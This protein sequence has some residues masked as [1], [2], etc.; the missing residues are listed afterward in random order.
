MAMGIA[1]CLVFSSAGKNFTPESYGRL[2]YPFWLSGQMDFESIL[3]MKEDGGLSGSLLLTPT[4][5]VKAWTHDLAAEFVSGKDFKV[6][7]RIVYFLRGAAVSSLTP[8]ELYPSKEEDAVARVF[9]IRSGGFVLAPRNTLGSRQTF[10]SYKFNPAEWDGPRPE[11]QLETLPRT[12]Q[13]LEEK[14]PLNILFFGDSITEGFH[15]SKSMKCAPMLPRWDELVIDILRSHYGCPVDSLNAS[16]GGT[17]SEWGMKTMVEAVEHPETVKNLGGGRVNGLKKKLSEYQPDLVFVAFGMN[18]SFS[19]VDYKAHIEG[20][21][22]AA[23]RRNP[24]VEFVL[25]ES[26]LPNPRWKGQG[27]VKAYWDVLRQIAKAEKGVITVAV[28]PMHE[29]MLERKAYGDLSANHANHPNDFLIRIH[30]QVILSSLVD[31][32]S[33]EAAKSS[34][35]SILL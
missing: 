8:A 13:M 32:S 23:R 14:Q 27:L 1:S 18:G 34:D 20:I 25:V 7:G 22:A 2:V 33:K 15:A 16:V 12:K 17:T 5:E 26:I 28:G 9:P 19:A 29:A 31:F 35:G 10:F 30:A 3:L 21:L 6:Q 24:G 11:Y 4:S